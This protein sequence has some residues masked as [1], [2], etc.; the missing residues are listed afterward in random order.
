MIPLED[1]KIDPIFGLATDTLWGL[2]CKAS[3][4]RAVDRI[5]KLKQRDGQKPLVLFVKDM[6][7]AQSLVNI[8]HAVKHLLE[9][10]W[11]GPITIIGEPRDDRYAHCYRGS[12]Q[13]GIRIPN[14]AD[15]LK[16]L[17][18]INQPLAVTSFNL[19]GQP[20][21]HKL[22]E[23]KSVFPG[24]VTQFYGSMP[25][26]SQASIVAM[27]IGERKLKLLRYTNE[28]LKQLKEDCEKIDGIVIET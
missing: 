25:R 19:S 6:E 14:H 13:L 16:L 28:Q 17:H 2:A 20:D 21:I 10:W 5:Y 22:S 4:L 3:D 1:A 18:W 26:L 11:P 12:T 27:Q 9:K 7:V 8:S 15:T 24:D 23:L